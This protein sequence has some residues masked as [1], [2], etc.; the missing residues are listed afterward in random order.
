MYKKL[1]YVLSYIL[2]LF[3]LISPLQ[4]HAQNWAASCLDSNGVATLNCIP[5]AFSNIVQ[6]ALIFVGTVAVFLLIWAGIKFIR[7]GGD[8]K[9]TQSARSIITYA[10][11]GLVLVLSSFGIIY[12][13]AYLTGANCITTLSFTS[14]K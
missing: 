14:C 4:A 7:S 8:P 2:F 9:Q 6:G 1:F 11:I 13:I 12:L 10:I 5:Y 3:L